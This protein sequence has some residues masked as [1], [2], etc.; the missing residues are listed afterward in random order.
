[1]PHVN[2]RLLVPCLAAAVAAGGCRLQGDDASRL[3][4]FGIT[5][6]PVAI[7]Y[8][9]D[10]ADVPPPQGVLVGS[11]RVH[12]G[13]TSGGLDIE[14]ELVDPR[15]RIEPRRAVLD[16]GESVDLQV[17]ALELS[18][19]ERTFE[20]EVTET[21]GIT[22]V[23]A[24]QKITVTGASCPQPPG[25]GPTVAVPVEN[26]ELMMRIL[27]EAFGKDGL[28]GVGGGVETV[29]GPPPPPQLAQVGPPT[30]LQHVILFLS[31]DTG[32]E[33]S[34]LSLGDLGDVGVSAQVV[35]HVDD[36][37][38]ERI[39]A[40]VIYGQAALAITNWNP[41]IDDFGM[42]ETFPNLSNVTD[43]SQYGGVQTGG[44]ACATSFATNAILFIEPLPGPNVFTVTGSME[45]AAFPGASG[46]TVSA[47]R[48]QAGGQ[49]VFVTDG[50]PGE[51]WSHPGTGSLA[52]TSTN[53]T[54]I[55]NLG[56]GP[57]QIRFLGEI[58][59]VS[60]FDSGTLTIVR[61]QSDGTVTILG[62]VDVGSGPIGLDLRLNSAGNIEVLSTG[63][64]D[65]TY[66]LTVLSPTGGVIGTPTTRTVPEGGLNPVHA[67]F[68]NEER[69]RISISCNGSDE[70]LIFDLPTS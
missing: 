47:F 48:W 6:T 4:Q 60:N 21:L 19:E 18:E 59:V 2:I 40:L 55:G 24:E 10:A 70:I 23:D 34:R 57:R 14:V 66:T 52:Q 22:D 35:S 63:F 1:M 29:I 33:L 50:Q 42:F 30:F 3:R 68:V 41:D 67:V 64:N 28:L 43:V 26:P 56:N 38:Q 32:E 13:G 12:N 15:L 9:F 62:T 46:N 7:T 69:T 51:L 49:T 17:Y 27:E 8:C 39:D 31:P 53:A 25:V 45:S 61:R 5:V 11:V 16:L 37:T 65:H 58:G 54:K 20:V 44:G 36:A